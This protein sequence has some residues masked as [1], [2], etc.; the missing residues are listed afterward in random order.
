MGRTLLDVGTFLVAQP[1]HTASAF[2]LVFMSVAIVGT[3][4]YAA[5]YASAG[6]AVAVVGNAGLL[7]SLANT[8][9]FAFL[10]GEAAKLARR[11]GDVAV[12]EA[13]EPYVAL[14]WIAT[15]S[16]PVGG[17]LNVV[18]SVMLW[19]TLGR[20]DGDVLAWALLAA[21]SGLV[22]F[23]AAVI[24]ACRREMHTRLAARKGTVPR[25]T[26][27]KTL[28]FGLV[29][30]SI[31]ICFVSFAVFCANHYRSKVIDGFTALELLGMLLFDVAMLLKLIGSWVVHFKT[32]P[33]EEDGDVLW[34]G[35]AVYDEIDRLTDAALVAHGIMPEPEEK[36]PLAPKGAAASYGAAD[37]P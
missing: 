15:G 29:A 22:T 18:G 37:D 35:F 10:L 1:P 16:M 13:V 11:D 21:G 34:C 12:A 19:P 32:L 31:F 14:L 25:A 7:Y 20:Y 17:A 24:S 27:F 23:G 30:L 26:D 6:T 3:C 33:E 4:V 36:A 8:P 5:G 9:V 28:T 2:G